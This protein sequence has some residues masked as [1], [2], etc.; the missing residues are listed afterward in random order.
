MHT[1]IITITMSPITSQPKLSAAIE[2]SKF[3]VSA[4]TNQPKAW[5]TRFQSQFFRSLY[6]AASKAER[7]EENR[8]QSLGGIAGEKGT[9]KEQE[10]ALESALDAAA[11]KIIAAPEKRRRNAVWLARTLLIGGT[12]FSVLAI[13][14]GRNLPEVA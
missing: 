13:C 11:E 6:D 12:A 5:E 10:A 1:L 7:K 8:M 4:K 2:S 3:S 9:R 14:L